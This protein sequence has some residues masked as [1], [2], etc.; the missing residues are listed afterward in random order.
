MNI[1]KRT[2]LTPLDRKEIDSM[3]LGNGPLLPFHRDSEYPVQ[4]FTK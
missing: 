4:R 2:R 1:H 3:G